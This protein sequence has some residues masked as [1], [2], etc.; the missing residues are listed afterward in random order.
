[1]SRKTWHLTGR[2]GKRELFARFDA[3]APTDLK[4][5]VYVEL[6]VRYFED[7]ASAARK[8]TVAWLPATGDVYVLSADFVSRADIE[9][10]LLDIANTTPISYSLRRLRS[11]EGAA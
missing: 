8:A 10:T 2:L 9:A 1:M 11:L 7:L 4:L 3:G 5:D 6:R